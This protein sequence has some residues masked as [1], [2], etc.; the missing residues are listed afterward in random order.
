MLRLRWAAYRESVARVNLSMSADLYAALVAAAR[1]VG[2][3]PA[4]LAREC[5]ARG[6]GHAEGRSEAD[7]LRRTVA[8]LEKRVAAL[9]AER[10]K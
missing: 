8:A 5:V 4:G 3:S 1:R 10:G 6:I 7:E 9:E 2:L